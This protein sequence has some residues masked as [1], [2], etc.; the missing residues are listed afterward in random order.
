[1]H[2]YSGVDI[3]P[4]DEHCGAAV[5]ALIR[6]LAPSS[7]PKPIAEDRPSLASVIDH[8]IGKGD[9]RGGV[10]Q[11]AGQ[12]GACKIDEHG[13]RG[14]LGGRWTARVKSAPDRQVAAGDWQQSVPH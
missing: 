4:T 7:S 11:L 13:R 1:M 2:F 6:A 5:A 14:A 8:D 12:A 3:S 10:E 9:A